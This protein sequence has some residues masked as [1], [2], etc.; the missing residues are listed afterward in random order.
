MYQPF[1]GILGMKVRAG[2]IVMSKIYLVDF[3][4]KGEGYYLLKAREWTKNKAFSQFR[5]ASPNKGD[6]LFIRKWSKISSCSNI[7]QLITG[8]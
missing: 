3:F 6:H 1:V 2:K 8:N 5:G 4:V 7:A